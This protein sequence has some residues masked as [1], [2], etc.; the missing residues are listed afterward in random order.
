MLAAGLPIGKQPGRARPRRRGARGHRGDGGARR[1]GAAAGR[2]RRR[3]RVQ[4]RRRGD[5]EGGGRRR[6]RRPDPRRRP[7]DGRS[8]SPR[9]CSAPAPSSGTA[10][11]ASSSWTPSA[12]APR[13]SR[14][15]SPRATRSAS[16]AAATRSRRSHKYGIE[17][18]IGYISTG[19]GAFLEMLEGKT[20]PALRR[21]SNAGRAG[22][23]GHKR[24]A[25]RG[26]A[27]L[28]IIAFDGRRFEAAPP[29][30]DPP[31]STATPCRAPPRS[32][33]RSAPRRPRPRRW[34]A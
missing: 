6:G 19:G 17:A 32:S 34:S 25:A 4:G 13:P 16:P 33:P 9:S 24:H 15:P 3:Q 23:R 26:G 8:C 30:G 5:G 27:A 29:H 31:R 14:A 2:R 21:S 10:R 22:E 7:A 20:L 11:S 18:D 28:R 1:R 12:T